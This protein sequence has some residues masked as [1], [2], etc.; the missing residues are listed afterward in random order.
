MVRNLNPK[1]YIRQRLYSTPS[2]RRRTYQT[3]NTSKNGNTIQVVK[4]A[5]GNIW[6]NE[7]LIKIVIDAYDPPIAE[8]VDIDD[9][10]LVTVLIDANYMVYAMIFL[11]NAERNQYGKL[12]EGMENNLSQ[13]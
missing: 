2:N 12:I 8:L 11:L 1:S 7:G 4:T 6:V 13:G 3:Q 9:V 10:Q 5:G